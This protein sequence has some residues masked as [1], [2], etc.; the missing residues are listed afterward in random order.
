MDPA[1]H[2]KLQPFAGLPESQLEAVARVAE[3]YEEPAGT[4]RIRE[5]DF[6]YE[7]IVL[8]E[9]TAEIVRDGVVVDMVGPG[10]F[11]GEVAVLRRAACE[12]LA[13][14]PPRRS[15][16]SPST[17]ITCA[18]SVIGSRRSPRSCTRPRLSAAANCHAEPRTGLSAAEPAKPCIFCCA[19]KSLER[20]ARTGTVGLIHAYDLAPER[21]KRHGNELEVREP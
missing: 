17:A 21:E 18:R 12:T 4:T 20:R 8:E 2:C 5:G 1:R 10:E 3:E 7:L 14:W 6:G 13:S 16:S 15:A 11:S 19:G 9:G